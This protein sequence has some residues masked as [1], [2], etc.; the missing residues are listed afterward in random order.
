MKH[1]CVVHPPRRID[2]ATPKVAVAK[3]IYPIE[4]IVA[5]KTRYKKV[6]HV[7]PEPSMKKGPAAFKEIPL[8]IILYV[9]C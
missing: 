1:E 6:F 9:V 5:S 8:I 3:A 4:R 7:P 2:A